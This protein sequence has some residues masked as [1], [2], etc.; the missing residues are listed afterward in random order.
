MRNGELVWARGLELNELLDFNRRLPDNVEACLHL[1]KATYGEVNYDMTH[2]YAVRPGLMLMHNGTI[3]QMA[4]QDPSLSD[5]S[6]LARLLGELLVGLSDEQ[7]SA[8]VR[9]PAFAKLTAPLIEG[10]MVVLGDRSG[11]VRL[12]RSWHILKTNEWSA[13]M[14]G[15]EV[16]NVHTWRTK[17]HG[18]AGPSWFH[19][20]QIKVP[21]FS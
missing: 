14:A 9:S 8:L 6:E 18:R 16:S 2:P 21:G 7:A 15:L 19:W 17:S 12:G 3:P 11:L 10:S 1:R 5:T 4:P 13:A 20:S